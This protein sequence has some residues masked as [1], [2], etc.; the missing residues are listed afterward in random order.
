[1]AS[2]GSAE[3]SV[4]LDL[5]Q[6]RSQVGTIQQLLST[7]DAR[8]SGKGLANAIAYAVPQ[9]QQLTR[10]ASNIAWAFENIHSPEL[11][12]R[13]QKGLTQIQGQ[14][15]TIGWEVQ[16][17]GASSPFER[18][19]KSL[20]NLVPSIQKFTHSLGFEIPG[21]GMAQKVMQD[22]IPRA[23]LLRAEF[24]HIHAPVLQRQSTERLAWMTT[25]A[26]MFRQEMAAVATPRLQAEFNTL[27][28]KANE[29]KGQLATVAIPGLKRD[30]A[31]Q[32]DSLHS[33][34]VQ[35][36]GEMANVKVPQLRA[37]LQ[38]PLNEAHKSFIRLNH[39]AQVFDAQLKHTHIPI[40]QGRAQQQFGLLQNQASMFQQTLRNSTLPNF[41]AQAGQ[42]IGQ[43]NQQI[44]GSLIPGIQG[45]A[46]G[47]FK[48]LTDKASRFKQYMESTGLP[49]LRIQAQPTVNDLQIRAH[50]FKET[51]RTV[52]LPWIKQT[53][54]DF[55]SELI[56]P[57][58]RFGTLLAGGIALKNIAYLNQQFGRLGLNIASVAR[59]GKVI[60]E[61]AGKTS[62]LGQIVKN[63]KFYDLYKEI[64][65]VRGAF[66]GI[67]AEARKFQAT[68]QGV[69]ASA[70]QS[71]NQ[72]VA[73]M[74]QM[75]GIMG[76]TIGNMFDQAQGVQS[77][78]EFQGITNA[79]A[80]LNRASGAT[81]E[82]IQ[83][84]NAEMK[85][86]GI[87]TSKSPI[88]VAKLAVEMTKL[89]FTADQVKASL[90]GVV[91]TSEATGEDLAQTGGIIASTINQ[92]GLTA[93]DAGRIGDM[94]A[95]AASNSAVSVST[96]GESMRYVGTTAKAARQTLED[97]TAVL[98][99]LG[100]AGLSGSIA[101]TNYAAAL[102]NLQISAANAKSEISATGDA[103]KLSNE[104]LHELSLQMQTGEGEAQGGETQFSRGGAIKGKALA[105]LGLTRE[106]LLTETGD[107]KSF[108]DILPVLKERVAD[109]RQTAGGAAQ[110]P[111][112]LNA[113]F[114]VEGGRA[115]LSLLGQTDEQINR[116]TGTLQAATG[117]SAQAADQMQ[118]GLAGSLVL[119]SG[120][121]S[122]VSQMVGEVFAPAVEWVVRGIMSAINMFLG[123]NPVVQKAI[124]LFG[125]FSPLL[126]FYY[127]TL[128]L[129]AAAKWALAQVSALWTLAQQKEGL[130]IVKNNILMAVQEVQLKANTV[131]QMASAKAAQFAAFQYGFAALKADLLTL[132]TKAAAM[133]AAFFKAN[134]GTAIAT[135]KTIGMQMAL[136]GGAFVA[137]KALTE[138]SA[139]AKIAA[140]MKEDTQ[141]LIEFR[142]ELNKT[143]E[144]LAEPP[145][146]TKWEKSTA[147]FRDQSWLDGIR[148]AI[149]EFGGTTEEA[150]DSLS[151][152][153]IAW[154]FL[155]AR[156]VGNQKAML[157]LETQMNAINGIY[158]E[159]INLLGKQNI[160]TEEYTAQAEK[161]IQVN[162]KALTGMRQQLTTMK[163]T[164]GA[165]A[166]QIAIIESTIMQLERQ[167]DAL[168]AKD[169]ALKQGIPATE[170]AVQANEKLGVSFDELMSA[171]E[172][173]TRATT[174]ENEK[175][176]AETKEKWAGQTKD[177]E[178]AQKELD[179]IEIDGTKKRLKEVQNLLKQI[180]SAGLGET[181]PAKQKE[182]AQKVYE[183]ELE[184]AKLR[185]ELADQE[186]K[187]RAE[188]EKEK[189]EVIQKAAQAANDAVE[190]SQSDRTTAAK[191]RAIAEKWTEEKLRTEIDKIQGDGLKKRIEN[192]NVELADLEQAYAQKE[193]AEEEYNS[194]RRELTQQMR[195]LTEESLDKEIEA[196]RRVADESKKAQADAAE[197]S[198]K[199]A[200]ESKKAAEAAIE[201]KLDALKNSADFANAQADREIAAMRRVSDAIDHQISLLE[202]RAQLTQAQSAFTSLQS[203]VKIEDLGK[204]TDIA[205]QLESTDLDSGVRAALEQQLSAL[206]I[207]ADTSALNMIRQRQAAENELGKQKIDALRTQQQL[208]TQQLNLQIQQQ[209][210]NAKIAL[211]EANQ[212]H[213]KQQQ[214]IQQSELN[215][216]KA[217]QSGDQGAI[218]NAQAQ[219]DLAK[220]SLITTQQGITDAQQGITQQQQ[221]AQSAKELQAV[222]QKTA[223]VQL[224]A[225]ERSRVAAQGVE[226]AQQRAV[227][228]AQALEV[229]YKKQS[230]ELEKIA[231]RQEWAISIRQQELALMDEQNNR[232]QKQADLEKAKSAAVIAAI[233]T[234]LS[235]A[236]EA[237]KLRATIADEKTDPLVKKE[238]QSQLSQLGNTGSVAEVEKRLREEKL[239]ALQQQ[240]KLERDSLV[241]A[242]KQSEINATI[243]IQESEVA[244]LKAQQN[245]LQAE[246]N[247]KKAQSTGDRAAIELAEFE[248]ESANKGVE[249]SNKKLE[250]A[251]RTLEVQLELNNKASEIQ[252]IEQASAVGQAKSQGEAQERSRAMTIAQTA[253]SDAAK[254]QSDASKEVANAQNQA[255]DAAERTAAATSES[256]RSSRLAAQ[257][258]KEAANAF[259]QAANS[260]QFAIGNKDG[261]KQ[262]E[263]A[264]AQKLAELTGNEALKAQLEQEKQQLEVDGL[265]QEFA[266][267]KAE[268]EFSKQQAQDALSSSMNAFDAM[269]RNGGVTRDAAGNA[270]TS[271][272]FRD[273]QIGNLEAAGAD[274][275]GITGNVGGD[276]NLSRI[277][278]E[279][280]RSF[281]ASPQMGQALAEANKGVESKLD[282]LNDNLGKI[283]SSRQNIT[284]SSPEPES[285]LPKV[286]QA[287]SRTRR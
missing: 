217:E 116:L 117:F 188:A 268:R 248:V 166:A 207:S 8:V 239:A 163:N 47:L 94:F 277:I 231:Q 129:V 280:Q 267:I 150:S 256:A 13:A 99:L 198:K 55:H 68:V 102:K 14:V 81:D 259:S 263:L 138:K 45:K 69:L 162:T 22:I 210:Q 119:I 174:L 269:N 195:S 9:A 225:Q 63:V 46:Q 220:D 183:Y 112:L 39:D 155:T 278:G 35:F 146:P 20:Q 144:A 221:A 2:I 76:P 41:Q 246:Y 87:Y 203:E 113:I 284:V 260:Q 161:Q 205:K 118:S 285:A 204:G 152:Y 21:L 131:W 67:T 200:E 49:L 101:G 147:A 82:Q 199:A 79:F 135:M 59:G 62:M 26:G 214:V 228:K 70:T 142:N 181:D 57:A 16:Q 122:T 236:E 196:Q 64:I 136:V 40:L 130:T 271:D 31:I 44:Q 273:M 128:R 114:G 100:N 36:R 266:A 85:R 190:K 151:D 270:V 265:K 93:D 251:Q 25:Q 48:D 218:A 75:A 185:G 153:G 52:A 264:A 158:Q 211:Q 66:A 215:L 83:A 11:S 111:V 60:S 10:E 243:A 258:A 245:Q 124:I 219:L 156:Q 201:A 247:L 257:S 282:K 222:Q 252:R 230:F 157:A 108:L 88:E 126:I 73:A 90:Y 30:A 253:A 238:A 143:A 38:E 254:K 98:G 169:A 53:G 17:F 286:L 37:Q 261:L 32:L 149:V 65:S 132:R 191:Q 202:A 287:I 171:V 164:K 89:G 43:I 179:T 86:L 209:A 262:R 92:F 95:A 61:L 235:K 29:F 241:L 51:L 189:L 33:R 197:A 176:R 12:G 18:W 276:M 134:W 104:E 120:S 140:T 170:A 58:M 154:N 237:E 193:I 1:M 137:F 91:K 167:N 125:T 28:G 74:N 72:M 212:A 177:A 187:D 279:A 224:Q 107:L 34:A 168:R 184:A 127:K 56:K 105:A 7:V 186:I 97:T 96:L 50:K 121:I 175:L 106:N 123:W 255:A 148:T 77:F 4:S 5:A 160:S 42:Q 178:D 141:A 145:P 242:H 206:G 216:L 172:K 227:E 19:G 208:E 244:Q 232:L 275:S 71:T 272:R 173:S 6:L 274:L 54:S 223:A 27:Q 15:S 115:I 165:S 3:F 84:V 133:A 23:Q 281:N 283:A 159:G 194:R 192:T 109:L 233:E 110:T 229:L 78:V 24:S 250:S 249:L 139:G 213:I 103:A 226:I 80:A 180:E 240:N 234:Q 182:I